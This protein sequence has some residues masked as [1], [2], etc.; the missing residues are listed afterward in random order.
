MRRPYQ[1]RCS[2]LQ[3]ALSELLLSIQALLLPC[4]LHHVA[5]RPGTVA[6]RYLHVSTLNRFVWG[7]DN[8]NPSRFLYPRKADYRPCCR[9]HGAQSQKQ[10]LPIQEGSQIKQAFLWGLEKLQSLRNVSIWGQW[11]NGAVLGVGWVFLHDCQMDKLEEGSSYDRGAKIVLSGLPDL[12]GF[13]QTPLGP[14]YPLQ[15]YPGPLPLPASSQCPWPWPE[16]SVET[17]QWVNQAQITQCP[18]ICSPVHHASTSSSRQRPEGGAWG[19]AE[20][21][22]PSKGQQL[23]SSGLTMALQKNRP[24]LASLLHLPEQPEM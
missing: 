5:H 20:T 21:P 15:P 24:R 13:S 11:G 4:S 8:Q 10:G 22:A 9:L 19:H 1:P 3:E 12:L 16:C 23:P 14:G 2:L 18:E 6:Y 17:G 7:L